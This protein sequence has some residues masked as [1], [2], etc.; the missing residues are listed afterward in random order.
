MHRG[1]EL[2]THSTGI[3]NINANP[4]KP[5]TIDTP[6]GVDK[7]VIIDLKFNGVLIHPSLVLTTRH[8]IIG[9]KYKPFAG[10]F[11]LTPDANTAWKETMDTKTS[12][13]RR[14][15]LQQLS[16]QLELNNVYLPPNESTDLA[17]IQLKR[18]L[19]TVK[20][21]PLLLDKPKRNWSNGYFVSYA[22]VYPLAGPNTMLS[23][24]KRHIA[25]MDVME[26]NSSLSEPYLVSKW[27]LEGDPRDPLNRQFI[28][29]EGMHKLKAF[30]QESDSGAAFIV[31]ASNQQFHVAGI[32][33]GRMVA[34]DSVGEV[35][36]LITPLYP[37]KEW[38]TGI[39]ASTGKTL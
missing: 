39:I 3:F 9:D 2:F 21:L 36:T 20:C 27:Q 24:N 19:H 12:Q 18:P 7:N 8:S 37:Y 34:E 11:W 6:D 31:K 32:H 10:S 5:L 13:E 15:Y 35:S 28:P 16:R 25:I 30:T 29:P 38:I 4:I 22:P 14:S 26:D 1:N 23:D 17:I 33:R